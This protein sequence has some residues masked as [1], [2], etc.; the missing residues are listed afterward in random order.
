MNLSQ[1]TSSDLKVIA[2]LVKEKEALEARLAKVNAR[3]A[4][5][6]AETPSAPAKSAGVKRARKTSRRAAALAQSVSKPAPAAAPVPTGATRASKQRQRPGKLKD[7]IVAI[8]QGAG[9]SG[10]T[11]RDIAGKLGLH[12]QRIYV[13]FNATGK[14][15][16]EIKKVA[17][18]TYTWGT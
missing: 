10:I 14:S 4:A 18:A 12:P 5:F 17:P 1:L 6:G 13:W 11:V 8:L 3:L 2:G 15:I 7:K 9:K 16:K